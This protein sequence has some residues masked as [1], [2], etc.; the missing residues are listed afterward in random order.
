[1]E[2]GLGAIKLSAA[3]RASLMDDAEGVSSMDLG[4]DDW[5]MELIKR[6]R[7]DGLDWEGGVWMWRG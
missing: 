1:V 5:A 2:K 6:D 3:W 4:I 7:E